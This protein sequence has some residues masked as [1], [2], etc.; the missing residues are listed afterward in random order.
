MT[1]MTHVRWIDGGAPLELS[2]GTTW[3]MPFARGT[4]ARPEAL[5]VRDADG[6][7]VASQTW[8]LATWP[9]G[10]L[11][12]AGLA[13]AATD[14]PSAEY[15]VAFDGGI[16]PEAGTAPRVDVTETEEA[17]TVG[18]GTLQME[19]RRRGSSLFSTLSRNGVTVARDGRLVSL[20]QDGLP[21]GAGTATREAFTG[22]VTDVVIE[23]R[24]PVRAVVRLEGKH[25]PDSA[26]SERRGWLPFVVRLYFYAGARS[27]RMVH[28]FIWDGD[29]NQDFLA[30]LG[31]RFTV[32][33]EGELHDRH[34]RIAGADGGFLL[35]AVRGLTGL[36]RDPGEAVRQAQLAGERTPPVEEWN[37]E[38]SSRLHLIP[39]WNDYTLAQLSA[40]GF[41]LRK[42]TAANHG[43]VGISGGTRA[44]GF[45]SLSD[46]SGGFGV[47]I[48][49]FW[50]SH[51]GQ[52]D[53]RNAATGEAS[54]TAWLYSPEAQP[55]DLRF[56]HDGLGQDTFEKQLDGLE[57]TYED[58]EPG[59]GNP[60]GIARTHELS[61]F[62]YSSTPATESLA[63]DAQAASTPALLQATPEYL[64]TARVFG[65]WTP[66]DRS[67]PAR[68]ELEDRLD[69][70]FDFYAGQVEQRRWYGFWN[71]GDVMHTYDFDR[72]VWRYDVGGYAWDNSELSP[73]LWLW[74]SY[75][76]SGRADVFRFAEAMTRHTGEVDVYHLGR[77]QGLGSRHNVQ[78]WGC[79]AKQLRISTPA[80]RR[81]YYYLTADERTGDL[82]TELVDSDQNFLGLDPVRKVRPDAD[83]YRPDRNALGVGLGTDWGSL[84][85]TW[86]TDWERTG[87]PRSRD[88]L[89]GTMADIGALKYGFLTGE[90]LY[91]LDKGRFD[92]GRERIQVSHLSAVFGLVEV[93]SELVDLVPDQEFE[94]AWLQYCR[95]FL[96][97]EAEQIEAVGTPLS[98]IHLTQAHSRLSAY[99]AARLGDAVLASR[100]WESFAE[101]GEHLNHG[102]A[103][104][105]K[106]IRPPH[107]LLPVDEAPTVSTNDASQFGLAVIQNLA[108]IGE[109]L[110]R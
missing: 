101:G 110:P 88:R 9:D 49:D 27:V 97:T 94:R 32:P 8:P 56:Y 11:K 26:T 102:W 69:F 4:V 92:A 65:D 87:N 60:T 19:I 24:G 34:V 79:S 104:T 75:L 68:A 47:G 38:V 17:V 63:A 91:D 96:A 44:A 71:Y 22:E 14:S 41:E 64:H 98:G 43:W 53:I 62:A 5:T 21:D 106:A 50:Q 58:Y 2:A 45:C 77:W 93:C 83:T 39:A 82:L 108:L 6:R 95:L 55:M 30:G 74:Y 78:H 103:F 66:V 76:R 107:V 35:E 25:L 37:E 46:P 72:H 13:L 70:L 109:H 1:E 99:A 20:L 12:W 85:A 15:R 51:P 28:S 73:D 7:P 10:S 90:A 42:R 80:Y 81:F 52:L 105:L 48:K 86:L 59:F 36:R 3:G 61:L 16:Q 23:Q 67:T 57:I 33:L 29:A 31:V 100:A 54:L 89:L 84:A 40:D 18:T